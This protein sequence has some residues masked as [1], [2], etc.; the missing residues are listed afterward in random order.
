MMK[1]AVI[2][3]YQNAFRTLRCY[4][5]LK[6]HEVLVYNDTEKNPARLA[7]RL[8]DADA[9]ILTQARSAFPRALIERLPKLRLI[10]QTGR[11]TGHIDIDA[12][13]EHGIVV[14]A[15]GFATPHPTAELTWGLIL[16]ALR[17]IPY[18]AQRLREGHWQS[19]V[20]SCV[21][22]KTLGIYA[23]GRIGSLVAHVGRAFGA[24]VLCWG[25]KASLARAQ[26]AGYDVAESRKTFFADS[27][28][29]SLH[30]PL[31][32]E[33]RGIVTGEDLS[34]MKPTALIVNSSRAEIIAEG[35]L[36]EALKAGRPG[37]A[38]VDVFEDEPV[39]GA[40][41]PLLK[42][43]NVVATPHLGYVERENYEIYYGIVIDQILAYASGEPINVL[44]VEALGKR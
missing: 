40:A 2:D 43:E 35:A 13:T 44:N 16:A 25:R 33:T 21:Q 19:T 14:S 15:A 3:D 26:E 24:R 30:L 29:L 41:H 37:F 42:M 5:K 8:Q 10:S 4:A 28:I 7:E 27:D 39:L 1:I 32:S 23:Y 6:G 11:S 38:A 18:E 34:C 31:S 12:C 17:H 20:G 9:V 36:V 22:G